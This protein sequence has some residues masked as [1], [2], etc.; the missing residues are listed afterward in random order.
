MLTVQKS[1]NISALLGIMSKLEHHFWCSLYKN[2]ATYC[3][4]M[5]PVQTYSLMLSVQ[6]TCNISALLGIMSK[7]EHHFWCSLYKNPAIY[8]LYYGSCL[9]WSI[10]Y[11]CFLYKN[12][13]HICSSRDHVQTLA[14]FIDAPCTKN[15]QHICSTMDPVWTGA[16]FFD[17]L[18]TKTLQHIRSPKIQN[19][20]SWPA[21]GRPRIN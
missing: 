10:I 5:D 19:F 12:M 11:W 9:N 20:R 16:S 17:A 1:C 13:Q 8:L 4:T 7:L 2:H 3:S 14:S 18:R 21:E 6:K 15:L